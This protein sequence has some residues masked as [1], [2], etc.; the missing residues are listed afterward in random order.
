MATTKK[1]PA[2]KAAAAKKAPAKKATTKAAPAKAA[3]AKKVPTGPTAAERAAANEKRRAERA[4][5][6]AKL[7]KEIIARRK[8][9]ETWAEIASALGISQGKAQVLLGV[10]EAGEP[11]AAP[12]AARI[13]SARD[14]DLMSWPAIAAKF[15]ITK[16]AV[17]KLYREAGGDPHASYIGKGGRYFGHEEKVAGSKA[18]T[19]G[20]KASGSTKK[21]SKAATPTT[22]KPIF[23]EDA[24]KDEVIARIEGKKIQTKMAERFG[25]GLSEPM[26]VGGTVKVGKDKSQTRVVQ[27]HDGMKTRTVALTAIVKVGR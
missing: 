12:T 15:G 18:A 5:T 27:F 14:K 20:A 16:A 10:H 1:A 22:L 7:T 24:D 25:G 17:Q 3:A 6:D 19:N 9:E 2:K 13:R 23:S 4:A 26:K 21:T 11:A 8:R